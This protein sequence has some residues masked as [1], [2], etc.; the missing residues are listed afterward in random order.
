MQVPPRS[1]A[2]GC[3]LAIVFAATLF[4]NPFTSGALAQSAP[5]DLIQMRA[6]IDS[7]RCLAQFTD[8]LELAQS[9]L[10]LLQARDE[11]APYEIFD[12]Q[13]LVQTLT[14][15]VGL[16]SAQQY[17]LAR[18]DSLHAAVISDFQQARYQAAAKAGIAEREIR[19]PLLGR[20]HP[21][22]VACLH[23]LANCYL[24]YGKLEAAKQLYREAIDIASGFLDGEHP[25]L[26][27]STGNLAAILWYEGDY[28]LGIALAQQSADLLARTLGRE[29]IHYGMALNTL[30][31][32]H[33]RQGD[34]QSA[35]DYFR[36]ALPIFRAAGAV[37]ALLQIYENLGVMLMDAGDYAAAEPFLRENRAL[38]QAHFPE[39]NNSHANN[40][41]NLAK[42]LVHQGDNATAET[43][44]LEALRIRREILSDDHP[45][46]ALS[47]HNLGAFYHR[48]GRLEEAASYYTEALE[49]RVQSLGPDHHDTI[50]SKRSLAILRTEQGQLAEAKSLLAEALEASRQG[51]SAHDPLVAEIRKAQADIARQE[52][53]F[54]EARQAYRDALAIWELNYGLGH[55]DEVIAFI[56]LANLNGIEGH[57]AQQESLLTRAAD[58]YQAA[59][60]KIGT[61][62]AQAM[63]TLPTPHQLLAATRLALDQPAAAWQALEQSLARSLSDVLLYADRR[64]LTN[65]ERAREDSLR[66]AMQVLETQYQSLLQNAE[67]DSTGEMQS[68]LEEIRLKFYDAEAKWCVLQ[69]EFR[70]KYP[71]GAGGVFP[72]QRI[73]AALVPTA[74]LVGWLEAEQAGEPMAWGYVIRHEGPVKW[75]PLAR[76]LA[77]DQEAGTSRGPI[78]KLRDLLTRGPG[79]GK[80]DPTPWA[81]SC[82]D[83]Y[84]GPMLPALSGVEEL[85]VIPT[86]NLLGVPLETF[87]D[88]Q[89]RYLGD[90]Y[91]VSYVPS[92]TI[93][94]WLKESDSAR[95]R[96]ARAGTALL[97]G[98][99][100]FC[101]QH[102]EQMLREQ[103]P[104]QDLRG[105]L[106]S[107][108]GQTMTVVTSESKTDPETLR[109]LPRLISTRLLIQD[110]QDRFASPLVLLGA[111]ASEQELVRLA[112]QDRLRELELIHIGT[113]AFT[114][115]LDP[116]YS[117]LVL[118]QVDLPDPLTAA[119]Q[120]QRIYRGL[121]T[122]T[123]VLREW[124]LDA[125]LVTLSGCDTGLG[126]KAGGEGYLGLAH[127]FLQAGSRSLLVSLWQVEER[128]TALL[129]KRFYENRYGWTAG[130]GG[131]DVAYAMTK[132]RALQEAKSWLRGLTD[133]T[134]FQPYRHPYYWSGFVLIGS[135][136]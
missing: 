115:D 11:T 56:D 1:P 97:V 98:D 72:L 123:D 70:H 4:V 32:F 85:C 59:R 76:L 117:A 17:Q 127:A 71:A 52:G 24:R 25:Q 10:A 105:A 39:P 82:W 41:N 58:S 5:E 114:D 13:Q 16:D 132:S 64:P 122:T 83:S 86:G 75:F 37:S 36:Q 46:L 23:N 47:I 42:L 15:A 118:S 124:T 125:D 22:T 134:G 112:A 103:L 9:Q 67:A 89:G 49:K 60:G 121:I 135:A 48:W 116:R 136:D 92:G 50:S 95:E 88:G 3:W 73:Q 61:A 27:R 12:A 8:A 102:H 53:Q 57:Y 87:R 93:L 7:L 108:P 113:H 133:P 126:R 18:A 90:R 54:A 84:I 109:R 120:G 96:T 20:N 43:R 30:G 65:P 29:H 128:A 111:D 106:E 38:L 2:T 104:A 35:I 119:T 40:L 69:Q 79:L 99:P 68:T 101:E 63:A 130:E 100:P 21:E 131:D 78:P 45:D 51:L 107:L 74:A 33:A 91:A 19:E 129:L 31:L 26:A 80:A 28:E 66:H 77:P 81:H 6:R 44:F 110:L 14:L 94:A 62:M 55:P 34:A